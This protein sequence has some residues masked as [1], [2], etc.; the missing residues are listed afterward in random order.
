MAAQTAYSGNPRHKP[1]TRANRWRVLCCPL[2]MLFGSSS[3]AGPAPAPE[4][5]PVIPVS[6]VDRTAKERSSHCRLEGSATRGLYERIQPGRTVVFKSA[7]LLTMR[8]SEELPSHD[9]VVRDGRIEQVRPSGGTVAADA[10]VIEA[11][12]RTLMPGLADMHGHL[13]VASWAQAMGAQVPGG[14]DGSQYMLPYDLQLFQLLA[15][16]ITRLEVMAGCPDALWMRD[17]IRSGALVGPRMRVGSPLIDGAPN[18]HSDLMSYIVGDRQGGMG[19]GELLADMGFDFAKPYTNLPAEGYEGLLE[20]CHRR[21]IRVM[22]HVPTAIG[23]EKAIQ[24]GQHGIAHASELFMDVDGDERLDPARRDRIVALMSDS[25][26]WLQTT[27][28]LVSVYEW[29]VGRRPLRAPDESWA[30][31]L[32]KM[33]ADESGPLVVM[34]LPPEN[35]VLG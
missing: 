17:S 25:G 12:G 35:V 23:A 8:G 30:S 34:T 27:I 21:G 6:L 13:L 29:L 4:Q 33:I 1:A 7:R 20:V 3:M 19:A 18:L 15:N 22:G 28:G 26:T 14:G 11:S 10:I 5:Q 32:Q 31:P 9:V 2:H 16:G 24:M